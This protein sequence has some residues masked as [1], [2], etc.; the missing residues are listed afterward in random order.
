MDRLLLVVL[1]V[2]DMC[3]YTYNVLLIL[4]AVR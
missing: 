4:Q 2:F 1:S 3:L